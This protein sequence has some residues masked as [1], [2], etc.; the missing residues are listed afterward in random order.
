MDL[1]VKVNS[2]WRIMTTP[3]EIYIQA[4]AAVVV[5]ES[6]VVLSRGLRS[7]SALLVTSFYCPAFCSLSFTHLYNYNLQM[8]P[9]SIR[10]TRDCSFD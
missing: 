7:L 10:I 6:T 8:L 1:V 4:N 5:T 3:L 9:L 2:Q